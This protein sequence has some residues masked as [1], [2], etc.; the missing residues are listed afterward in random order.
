MRW[1][2]PEVMAHRCGGALC[3]ENTL[4]GLSVVAALGC[5]GVEF[6]VMLS[7][8]GS[9]WLIHDEMLER[10]TNGTGQ[11]CETPDAV[12]AGLSAGIRHHRAFAGVRMATLADAVAAC[13]AHG[14]VMNVEIKPATGFEAVTAEVVMRQLCENR[15]V[16]GSL[17]ISS[18]S[19]V[20]L[21]VVHVMAPHLPAGWLVD[22]VPADWQ[23]RAV[24]L[25]VMAIHTHCA[26]LTRAQVEAI[27]A[28]G[29]QVAVYTE[30]DPAHARELRAWGVACIITDRPDL[31]LLS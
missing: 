9:P 18:F 3:P 16:G 4:A 21:E 7:A 31:M 13:H 5:R 6:D 24:R 14:L 12:L 8:D 1:Q 29:L 17:V 19:E 20:A 2:Y 10:T 30:N 27:R 11:V 25:G 28:A 22:E 23:A 26:R 15:E